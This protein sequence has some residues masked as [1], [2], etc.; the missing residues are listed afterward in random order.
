MGTSR[1]YRLGSLWLVR[2]DPAIGSEIRKT[3]PAVIISATAFN[4]RSKV[5][6]LPITSATPSSKMLPVLVA[7][8]PSEVNGLDVES[9]VVCIALMTFD[10][11]RL[12]KRLGKL[13]PE[14]IQQIQQVITTYL[15]LEPLT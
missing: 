12:L 10:K 13:E 5:T 9:Y 11:Q 1:D 6:V 15:D 4:Q 7:I 2:F 3:R 8:A 14:Q